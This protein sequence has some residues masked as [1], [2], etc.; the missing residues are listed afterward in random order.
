MEFGLSQEQVLLQ[1]N[2]NRFLADR[3]PLDRVRTFAKQVPGDHADI[4]RGLAELGI[5]ALLVPESAG[6]LG[7]SCLDAAL[8][9]E[10]LG[11]HAAPAPFLGSA[12]AAPVALADGNHDDLLGRTADGSTRLGLAVAEAIGARAD[13]GVEANGTRLS[14]KCL[15]VVDAPAE[16]YLVADQRRHLYLLPA[17][18]AGIT[19]RNLTTIDR[20]RPT[21]E[22]QLNGAEARLV[23]DDPARLA[24]LL[25]VTRVMLAADTLGA[26]QTMLDKAVDYAGERKQFGRPIGSFQAVKHLCAEM[27]AAL[28]P[29]RALVWYAAHALDELPEESHLTACHTKAHLA[30]VGRFVARTATEVHGGMGFT[31]LLGLHY[32]FKRIGYNRQM[33][34]TPELL[35]EVAARAQGLGV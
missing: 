21:A 3:V 33:L 17:D 4:W 8:V 7:M 35:R 16:V 20:T 34:G 5:P 31:D 32:W 12:V 24:R 22:L 15:F 18:A 11:A 26:A 13:A 10:A 14:G 28:E 23:S 25:D 19:I 30:E 6:G 29:C 2:V 27:A 1:D 9:A